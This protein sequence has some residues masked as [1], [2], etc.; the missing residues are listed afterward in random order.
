M[1]TFD[2]DLV[3]IGGGQGGLPASHMAANL[4]AKVALIEANR[5]GGT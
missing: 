5:V 4:G 3:V 2:V 1:S